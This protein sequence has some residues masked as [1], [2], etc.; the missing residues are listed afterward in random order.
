MMESIWA[1]CI[2]DTI[3]QCMVRYL[4]NAPKI[5]L[6]PDLAPKNASHV[7]GYYSPH[8]STPL[9]VDHYTLFVALLLSQCLARTIE[10]F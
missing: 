1:L 4:C 10:V 8:R 3:A 5:V 6:D 2:V 9:S 7:L